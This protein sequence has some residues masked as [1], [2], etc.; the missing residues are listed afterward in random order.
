[1]VQAIERLS[2]V[3]PKIK[4]ALLFLNGQCDGASSVDG[5]GFNKFDASFGRSLAEQIKR[6]ESLSQ[7]QQAS[8]LKMLE[9]YK[10]QLAEAEL[11]LPTI[12]ELV[13]FL[14]LDT[15]DD[16]EWGQ[17][18]SQ[19]EPELIAT[20]NGF[21]LNQQQSEAVRLMEKWW[22]LVSN[23]PSARFFCLK[24]YAGTGKTTTIQEFLY[25]IQ[26]D[27][28]VYIAVCAPTNKATQVLEKMA[29]SW[30]LHNIDFKTIYQLLGMKLEIDDDGKEE[31]VSDPD[32][33]DTLSK[34]DL[35]VC[36]EASMIPAKIWGQLSG[37]SNLPKMIFMGDPGQLPPIGEE[38]SKVFSIKEGT[39]LT[40]V[41]RYGNVIG[42]LVDRVRDNLDF[43]EI[44]QPE[45]SLDESGNG[46]EVLDKF[47]WLDRIVEDFK[48]DEYKDN[49]DHVRALAWTNKTVQWINAYVRQGLF[50]E[51][52]PQYI[53]GEK[54]IA[55]RPIIS[56]REIVMTNSSEGTIASAQLTELNGFDVWNLR[57]D[58][59]LGTRLRVY[60]I[61]EGSK[62]ALLL[63]LDDLKQQALELPNYSTE[64]KAK[65]REY[66]ALRDKFAPLNHCYALTV[67]KSQGS[68]FNNVYVALSDILKNRK[69]QERNQLLYVAYSR[70]AKKLVI[71][72]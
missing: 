44:I 67:H 37:R 48:S 16:D 60:C 18:Y 52:A 68:T 26:Q 56:G 22:D 39:T 27:R 42:E 20:Q 62:S 66:F 72:Q 13:S 59:D 35:V 5:H 57:V 28:R 54:L 7:I 36:D 58:T 25:R 31:P 21:T 29:A 4:T 1:M 38:K 64:R 46:I 10:K 50:G 11:T 23:L 65:W 14:V 40:Q 32:K 45:T 41:M 51:K 8:A 12:N 63:K 2:I 15:D 30:G 53:V 33:S 47:E 9:K 34:Y 55:T 3:H 24:G 61:D 70:A 17:E 49:S 6:T 69:I 71:E 43:A 19:P